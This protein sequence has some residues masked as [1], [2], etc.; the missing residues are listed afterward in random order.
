M[1][2]N[3]RCRIALLRQTFFDVGSLRQV[4]L[5][6]IGTRATARLGILNKHWH[7]IAP[8][9]PIELRFSKKPNED[10]LEQVRE[11]V[12]TRKVEVSR[13]LISTDNRD[14]WL[15]PAVADLLQGT[16]TI[17]VNRIDAGAFFSLQN[18][19]LT[20]LRFLELHKCC[21][22]LFDVDWERW[23]N[24]C[25]FLETFSVIYDRGKPSRA[26]HVVL[27]GFL[28]LVDVRIV[29]D[30]PAQAANV[31]LT[32][33]ENVTSVTLDSKTEICD[34]NTN[35]FP[36][37]RTLAFHQSYDEQASCMTIDWQ[38]FPALRNLELA[39]NMLPNNTTQAPLSLN[40]LSLEHL[41]AVARTD[42]SVFAR[43]PLR[44]L[45]VRG[46]LHEGKMVSFK[47]VANKLNLVF[48]EDLHVDLPSAQDL[49][50]LVPLSTSLRRLSLRGEQS[51]GLLDTTS[52]VQL[53]HLSEL[54]ICGSLD[55]VVVDLAK[56]EKCRSL[57]KIDLDSCV[58]IA[59]CKPDLKLLGIRSL[60]L[61]CVSNWLCLSVVPNLR[62]L[63]IAAY[64]EH[65]EL[66]EL[67]RQLST[68]KW[69][70]YAD[71]RA[72]TV[73]RQLNWKPSE[74]SVRLP[75][76]CVVAV[77]HPAPKHL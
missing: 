5:S 10:F 66:L 60:K 19:P 28:K 32:L 8:T 38:R 74:L 29:C 54:C 1:Q 71:F 55:K 36:R 50:M 37:L 75:S 25:P 58:E 64:C 52:L 72:M 73:A 23:F 16:G 53:T 70:E 31:R 2:P 35:V 14:N 24:L 26:T 77:R 34:D 41:T 6:F 13:L 47:E 65:S 9:V 76:A 20:R 46:N 57:T 67:E 48:L 43:V 40:C 49:T 4:I 30:W 61:N 45:S 22:M 68:L 59:P 3:K 62:A 42:L 15:H 44:S 51:G 7:G 27:S 12:R 17:W 18:P 33:P 69:L 63:L 56:L 39:D 11:R 21:D